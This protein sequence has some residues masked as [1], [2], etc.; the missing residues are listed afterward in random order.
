MTSRL[1]EMNHK[2]TLNFR[3]GKGEPIVVRIEPWA[4]EITIDPG[5]SLLLCFEGPAGESIEV[6]TEPNALVV[7]GWVGSTVKI[8]C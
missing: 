2:Q 8:L 5:E 4:D 7:Y 3:N 1:D 6:E